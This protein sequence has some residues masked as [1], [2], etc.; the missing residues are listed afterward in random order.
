MKI[1][2]SIT[3]FSA[4]KSLFFILTI[5]LLTSTKGYSQ[6]SFTGAT[7]Q[8][9][10]DNTFCIDNGDITTSPVSAGQ[11]VVVNVV[12]GFTYSF[13]VPN[14]FAGTENITLFS[15]E[16]KINN[17]I[18]YGSGLDGAAIENWTAP[19]S[20]QLKVLLSRGK[21]CTNV[22]NGL[23]AALTLSLNSVGNTQDDQELFGADRWV[24]HVYNWMGNAP[25]GG[26]SPATPTQA[27]KASPF[28][29]AN[30]VGYNTI[31]TENFSQNFGGDA[32]CFPV[33]SAVTNIYTETFAVRY[34]M[35]SSK[36]GCYL[37]NV[38][39]DDGIR[40]YID[41]VLVFDA[42][43][44]QSNTSYCNNLV[45]L[46]GKSEIVF[47][48]YE[49]GG[50]NTVAFSLTEFIPSANNITGTEVRT[51]CSGTSPGILD[52]SSYS[53][54]GGQNSGI[55]YQW[56]FS[57]DNV[58]FLD[59]T[60]ATSEDFT[61]P[62]TT[63][64]TNQVRYYRRVLKAKVP[65]AGNCLFYTN[66]IRVN[67]NTTGALTMGSIA[68]A[69]AQCASVSNQVYSVPAVSNA[70]TYF[71]S[72]PTGWTIN[73][74]QGTNS[75]TVTTGA[76][77]Q[78]G[79]LTVIASNGCAKDVS[80]TLAVNVAPKSVGGTI[81]SEQSICV[82]TTP[83]DLKL[84]GQTGVVVKWQKADDINFTINVFDFSTTATT[85]PGATIGNLTSNSYF[86][87]VVK[88]GSCPVVTS[89]SVLITVNPMP[90]ISGVSTSA[91]CAGSGATINL[92]GLLPNSTSTIN[93][94]INGTA[95]TPVTGV[96]SNASGLGS[97][98]SAVLT[99]NNNYQNLVITGVTTTSATPNCTVVSSVNTQVL[100]NSSI[101][102]TNT[103]SNNVNWCD[104]IVQWEGSGTKFYLDVATTSTFDSGTILSNYNNYDV[105]NVN[106]IKL[107]GLTAGTR[108]Y[109]RVRSFS[110]CG[111]SANSSVNN[112]TTATISSPT[113]DN[114]YGSCSSW[115]AQWTRIYNVSGNAAEGYFLDVATDISFANYVTGYQGLY[116]EDVIAYTIIGLTPGTIYYY[117]VRAKTFCGVGTNSNVI[118]FT[119]TG[120]PA[121]TIGFITQPTCSVPSGSFTFSNYKPAYNYQYVFSPST[122]VVINEGNVTAPPGRYTVTVKDNG[123]TSNETSFTID[124]VPPSNTASAASSTPTLC[125]STPLAAITHTTTGATGISNSGNAG[126]NGLPSGV[127]ATWAGNQI[128]ISGTPT[129]S[130]IFNY[131]IPLTGGCGSA[132]AIG[133]IT[134]NARPMVTFTTLPK[135]QTCG[136]EHMI[137]A[138]QAGKYNYIWTVAGV[139]GI[140]YNLIARGTSV[141][142]DIVIEWLT[143]GSKTVTVNYSNLNGCSA[144]APA[145]Y[146]TEVLVTDRGRVKGG[147][148]FCEG[149]PLPLLTL[150][151]IAGDNILYPNPSLVLS[152]QQ[153]DDENITWKDI[154]NTK[155]KVTYTPQG[156]F[157]GPFRTYR[158]LIQNGPCAKVA[159]ETRVTI[160]R[161]TAPLVGAVTQASCLSSISS[162][163][164]TGLPNSGTIIQ[165]GSVRTTY[166]ISGGGS[167]IISGLSAGTYQFAV[168]S[169]NC[170]SITT[171]AVLIKPVFNTWNGN[172]WSDGGIAPTATQTMIFTGD[173]TSAGGLS[174][175]SCIINSGNVIIRSG[176]TLALTDRLEVNEAGTFTLEDKAILLQENKDAVNK[177]EINVERKVTG[178]RNE[179]GKAVDY[180]YWGSPVEGQRTKGAGGFSPGTPNANFFF[181][182]EANDRFYETGDVTFTPGR[183]YAVRAETIKNPTT[184]SP[185]T[186]YDKTYKFTGKVNNGTIERNIIRS[187]DNPAGVVHGYNLVGNPY[188]SNIDFN[189]LY[190]ANCVGSDCLIYN[191]AWFW[192]N[193]VYTANQMGSGYS[194]N[195]Y[196]IF[197][198]TGGVSATSPYNG[199]LTP[200]GMIGVGQAF[201]V[202]KKAVGTGT[203]QFKNSNGVGRNIRVS[204]P[205]TFFQKE[206]GDRNKFWLK[207]ISPTQLVNSQL[208]GYVAGAT[209]G[210]EQDFDAEAFGDF[211]DLFYSVLG[212]KKMV[213][214]GRNEDFS[215]DDKVDLG[216]IFFQNGVYTIEVGET[217]GIFA[218][219]QK[220]YLKDKQSNIITDLSQGSYS[221]VATKGN[222]ATRFEILYKPETVLAT[223]SSVKEAVVVYRSGNDFVVK[224]SKNK[225]SGIELY[226]TTGRLIYK[227][228]LNGLTVV[229]PAEELVN[230]VYILK[231]DRS[232]EITTKK[233]LR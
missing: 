142:S 99:I 183:G 190:L 46:N 232:G 17:Q 90:T 114:G 144:V 79:N 229:I 204:S 95:Q 8:V 83:A 35:R 164:L 177:G 26:A 207:L 112:F 180:V 181:Y 209:D 70:L 5:L 208:I 130:G 149:N 23:S 150:Y 189:E 77:G 29:D 176:H 187:P 78:N 3:N 81:A 185:Y 224:S 172:S 212:N 226:D 21:D 10:P 137:Y 161:V 217:E 124:G 68:G 135:A 165:T 22:S 20:G 155:G 13:S 140:D 146:S 100:V 60:G 50:Q 53:C 163:V 231:I 154:P 182:N 73:S 103:Q 87:A 65:N 221:F 34:K 94:T 129:A 80:Q 57:T 147:G 98:I 7:T 2:L 133:T 31:S 43:K 214:Q 38:S 12:K 40:V 173:F 59:L 15:F 191:T 56:Q 120:T 192:T 106:K 85:L 211:S 203:L 216:A 28:T 195:N 141:D 143:A 33:V 9:G 44:N 219:A 58:T 11:Y 75:I 128:T 139:V 91:V 54:T 166:T 48:Y 67:T 157:P 96:V 178:L 36:I 27:A 230:T 69:A 215:A 117:R 64:P 223:E 202:Q 61:P 97:F 121:P 233:I 122:G 88:S 24:G 170:T 194:G 108:Y 123:C 6:C 32:T 37:L 225:I 179:P 197:N 109:F 162:V 206:N 71:W 193:N 222:N 126:A 228:S 153:S 30:Y 184:G 93:Y 18:G 205:A 200:N 196:A 125:I 148:T 55:S 201:I 152:W 62:S 72:I 92:T 19:F 113:A 198:G 41:N 118:K 63:T 186:Q 151:S 169:E 105:G 174:A 199:G 119:A 158:V 39:G 74:G 102:P 111:L 131:N 16:G 188:P 138:T 115:V 134:V 220:I 76:A 101:A 156:P 49:N 168:E 145:T 25:P 89:A 160:K 52:G 14:I 116:V 107:L 47:D 171:A 227:K 82:G 104:A 51:V 210:Y 4:S 213:I 42:W 132:S 159:I 66:V 110:G 1:K 45:Y 84:S 218:G 136:N 167:Q 175:C 86:R 127:S